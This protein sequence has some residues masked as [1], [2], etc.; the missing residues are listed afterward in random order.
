LAIAGV[1]GFLILLFIILI[2]NQKFQRKN[3][4]HIL[5]EAEHKLINA[6]LQLEKQGKQEILDQQ[7]LTIKIEHIQQKKKKD[8]SNQRWASIFAT[9]R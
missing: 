3:K 7:N 9:A 6:I 2:Y 4:R 8:I 5:E 1:L